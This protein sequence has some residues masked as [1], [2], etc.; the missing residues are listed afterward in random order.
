[1]NPNSSRPSGDTA[2]ELLAPAAADEAGGAPRLLSPII[3][4]DD[5]RDDIFFLRNIIR[6]VG[7]PHRFQHFANGDAAVAALSAMLTGESTHLA[8]PL[9]CL[10]D[11]KMTGI[12][13]FDVLKWIRSQRALDVLPVIMFSSSD[14][15][16]HLAAARELGAQSYV[17]KYPSPS[18]MRTLLEEAEAFASLAP[19]KQAF[20]HWHY[21]FIGRDEVRVP[22]AS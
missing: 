2:P 5:D 20:V 10:L 17:K 8:N 7:I 12:S 13:G 3:A 1:M 15:P 11:I 4:V 21:R 22:L 16:R 14:D 19:P 18:A 9:V 6:Q